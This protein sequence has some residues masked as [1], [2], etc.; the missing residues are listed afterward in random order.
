MTI[1][2]DNALPP[3]VVEIG[4][5]I[6]QGVVDGLMSASPSPSSSNPY[7]TIGNLSFLPL[8][9]GTMN[10]NVSI[11]FVHTYTDGETG[12]QWTNSSAVN[13]YGITASSVN[14]DGYSAYYSYTGSGVTFSD[15]NDYSW[16]YGAYGI[17]V[18]PNSSDVFSFTSSGITFYD[19]T[20]Q[21]TAAVSP[22]LTPYL[23]LQSKWYVLNA[24]NATSVANLTGGA[25]AQEFGFQLYTGVTS[26]SYGIRK[27]SPSS[28][29]AVARGRDSGIWDY[30]KEIVICGNAVYSNAQ[31][32]TNTRVSLGK[33]TSD[34]NGDLARAGIGFKRAGTGALQLMVHN[35]TALTISTNGTY[36]PTASQA[37]DWRI[38][39]TGTGGAT[40]YV[41][42]TS[43]ATV[44]GCPTGQSTNTANYIQYE[45][46]C[47]ATLT[48]Q[49]IFSVGNPKIM[50]GR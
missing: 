42:D 33:L 30:S 22:D 12:I 39:A 24:G 29:V 43:V 9:G 31:A 44:T 11:N 32:N 18:N 15:S 8:A 40:L 34:N 50:Q 4:N 2:V 41:N 20:I 23:Q 21:T 14:N 27:F 25:V 48:T 16:S 10:S 7:A 46:D 5:E 36:T 47:S 6:T 37:F 3:N 49:T 28:Q 19:G 1:Q 17:T 38:V 45:I 13:Q 35:G 26:G